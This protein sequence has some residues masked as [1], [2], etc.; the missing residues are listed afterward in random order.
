MYTITQKCL[1]INR[2]ELPSH[3]QPS[4]AVFA[5]HDK[6]PVNQSRFPLASKLIDDSGTP[7]FLM[8]TQASSKVPLIF[9]Y[10]AAQPSDHH[11]AGLWRLLRPLCAQLMINSLL[12]LLLFSSVARR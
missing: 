9:A 3:I 7:P 4:V 12:I 5:N 6:L 8:P 2:L 1:G 10:N 11:A